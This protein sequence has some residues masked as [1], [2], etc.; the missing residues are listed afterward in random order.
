VTP[1]EVLYRTQ[2]DGFWMSDDVAW[3]DEPGLLACAHPSGRETYNAVLRYDPASLSEHEAVTRVRAHQ[4]HGMSRWLVVPACGPRLPDALV[5]AGYVAGDLHATYTVDVDRWTPRRQTGL[6]VARVTDRQTLLDAIQV[7]REAFDN[8]HVRTDEDLAL[9][10]SQCAPE[11][12]RVQR[13]VVYDG[14][15]PVSSGGLTVFRDLRFAFLWA[16][17]T[18][19]DARGRGA[20][21]ELVAARIARARQ[22]GL[23]R[24]G[25]YAKLTTSAPIV[26]RQGFERGGPMQ[27]WDRRG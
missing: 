21:G 11:G 25:L 15:R 27:Y 20:Y 3:I 16:G 22:L 6:R 1:D 19:P 14:D 2:W 18:V 5:D 13:Y 10:L 24:V 17:G 23:T 12:S 26:A 7:M 9:E 8:P 4:T